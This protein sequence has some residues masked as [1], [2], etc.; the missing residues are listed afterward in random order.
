MINVHGQL[1]GHEHYFIQPPGST[2]SATL[3]LLPFPLVPP[4]QRL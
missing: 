2:Q 3:I 1:P 4:L